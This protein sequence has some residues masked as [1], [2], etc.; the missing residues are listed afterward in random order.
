MTYDHGRHDRRA[1][2]Q[3]WVLKVW[4]DSPDERWRAT[5]RLPSGDQRYF[6]RIEALLAFLEEQLS[7]PPEAP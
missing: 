5:I 6:G 7:G 4:W 3:V 1:E 2:V